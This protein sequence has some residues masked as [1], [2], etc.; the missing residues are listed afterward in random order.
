MSMNS[1][2]KRVV[3]VA[4]DFNKDLVDPM[5]ETARTELAAA[6]ADRKSVV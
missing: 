1:N 5:I 2:T 4:A 6:G 3:V